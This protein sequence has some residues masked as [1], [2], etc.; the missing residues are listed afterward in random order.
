[1]RRLLDW[2]KGG[3]KA[4]GKS[5]DA[6]E[7]L[8]AAEVARR[9][10]IE[11]VVADRNARFDRDVAPIVEM[12]EGLDGLTDRNGR[13][14]RHYVSHTSTEEGN[15]KR[16]AFY[17]QWSG[18]DVNHYRPI[19][20]NADFIGGKEIVTAF[21]I[22]RCIATE[23]HAG[24]GHERT[25]IAFPYCS[26]V[27][28]QFW[29][30]NKKSGIRSIPAQLNVHGGPRGHGFSRYAKKNDQ[31]EVFEIPNEWVPSLVSWAKAAVMEMVPLELRDTVE[32]GRN[33]KP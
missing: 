15:W 18:P 4:D 17:R 26:M 2:L 11:G 14:I 32:D 1:M 28:S 23:G 9:A 3:V 29:E 30:A 22:T 24:G 6:P 21:I 12:L 7:P 5:P 31:Y 13:Q 16:D 20:L 19:S 33:P 8:S 10:A 25:T 27:G